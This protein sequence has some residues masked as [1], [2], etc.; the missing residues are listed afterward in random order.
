M[1]KIFVQKDNPENYLQVAYQQKFWRALIKHAPRVR[2]YLR[3]HG[4]EAWLERYGLPHEPW[5]Q[6]GADFL[7]EPHS[8]ELR[9]FWYSD[10]PP[11]TPRLKD[12]LAKDLAEEYDPT[13]HTRKTWRARIEAYMS[14]VEQAY[15]AA[16]WQWVRTKYNPQHVIWLALRLEGHSYDKIARRLGLL[17]GEDAIRKGV[18]SVANLLGIAAEI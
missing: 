12:F 11:S 2:E 3:T 7:A 6:V 18:K 5:R 15:V 16:G 13:R 10:T 8:V 9:N 14:A 4:V 17:L 1:A